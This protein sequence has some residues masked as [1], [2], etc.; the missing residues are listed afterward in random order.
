MTE[1][2]IKDFINVALGDVADPKAIAV[3]E[4]RGK[5][6]VILQYPGLVH[7]PK[8]IIRQEWEQAKSNNPKFGEISLFI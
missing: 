3:D 2:E 7:C 6:I 4:Y 8:E 5:P 1:Q